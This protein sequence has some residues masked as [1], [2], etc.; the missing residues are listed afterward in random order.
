MYF[1]FAIIIYSVYLYFLPDA[2][3]K[4]YLYKFQ[5][6]NIILNRYLIFAFLGYFFVLLPI[7]FLV[8][9]GKFQKR[10]FIILLISLATM[11]IAGYYYFIDIA[12]NLVSWKLI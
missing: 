9:K 6:I 7:F 5:D 2:L 10:S 11:I 1:I 4:I 3:A 12:L 8:Q